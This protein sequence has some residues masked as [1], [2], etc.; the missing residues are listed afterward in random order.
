[1]EQKQPF[2]SIHKLAKIFEK[3]YAGLDTYQIG[4]LEKELLK[5]YPSEESEVL[6]SAGYTEDTNSVGISVYVSNPLTGDNLQ[7]VNFDKLIFEYLIRADI[8][9]LPQVLGCLE[10]M[11]RK[12]GKS[13]EVDF[14]PVFYT[15]DINKHDIHFRIIKSVVAI[16]TTKRRKLS[17]SFL[18]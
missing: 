9:K 7:K 11:E 18:L 12:G 16:N 3:I 5:M 8:S 1:M 17:I 15:K 2:V 13:D 6:F 10:R 4:E 14:I